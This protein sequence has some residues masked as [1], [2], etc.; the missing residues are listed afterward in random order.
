MGNA[1]A[2]DLRAEFVE[3]AT[4]LD[5]FRVILDERPPRHPVAA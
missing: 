4:A 3:T 5:R 2:A 1:L